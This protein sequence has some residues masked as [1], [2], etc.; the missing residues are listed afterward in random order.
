MVMSCEC[1]VHV[2]IV[3]IFKVT[4]PL[5]AFIIQCI[6]SFLWILVKGIVLTTLLLVRKNLKKI[7]KKKKLFCT[8]LSCKCTLSVLEISDMNKYK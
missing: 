1:I 7:K 4:L 3:F 6:K 8:P 2:C 5:L